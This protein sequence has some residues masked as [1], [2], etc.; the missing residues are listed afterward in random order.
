MG[1]DWHWLKF[2]RTSDTAADY[3][4]TSDKKDQG[5][6]Q[7]TLARPELRESGSSRARS[8]QQSEN[9]SL[10]SFLFLPEQLSQ[11]HLVHY[12]IIWLK[13]VFPPRV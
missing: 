9:T 7:E 4:S 6:L 8:G 12:V 2:L 11:L 3:R 1:A 5:Q 13:S 10:G